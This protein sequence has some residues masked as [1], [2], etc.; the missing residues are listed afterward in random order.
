MCV[1]L[2]PRWCL[3]LWELRGGSGRGRASSCRPPACLLLRRSTSPCCCS[4]RSPISPPCS[5]CWR[6]WP[7]SNRPARPRRRS[8][9]TQ[10]W[11][12]PLPV[13]PPTRCGRCQLTEGFFSAERSLRGAPP[14]RREP[15]PQGLGAAHAAAYVSQNAAGL[16]EHLRGH[17][18]S[19]RSCG[20]RTRGASPS[21]ALSCVLCPQTGDGLCWKELL[22]IRSPHKLLYALEIIE[23]LGKPNRRIHRES[24]V[25][26]AAVVMTTVTN[27]W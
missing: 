10:R 17:G 27:Q 9:R 24:T 23:A 8:R 15:V 7:A 18:E 19:G 11:G 12:L 26:A 21:S 22:R 6:C 25:S 20:S 5:S 14:P 4:C 1:C 3:C 16:P 13:A 2:L